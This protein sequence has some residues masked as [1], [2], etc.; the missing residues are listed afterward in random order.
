M[1]L[2]KKNKC[3]SSV[4]FAVLLL[5]HTLFISSI[6]AQG[7]GVR[8][9][10]YTSNKSGNFDIYLMNTISENHRLLTNHPAHDRDPTWSP[11]GRFLAYASNRDGISKIYVMDVRTGEH[12]RLTQR[13]AKEWAP[14]WSPDGK[15]IAFDSDAPEDILLMEWGKV[16]IASHIYKADINGENL[17]QLTD[18]GK[19]LKPSWSP[20]SQ[21][22]AFVSYHRGN[23]RKGIYVMDADGR[24]LRRL[25]DKAVQALNGILQSECTW[26][27]DGKQ[28]AFSM[29]V[30]RTEQVHLCAMD[31][32]GK[33]FRQLTQDG[34]IAGHKNVKESPFPQVRHPAW[35]PNGKWIVYVYSESFVIGNI[36]VI[37]ASGNGHGKPLVEGVARYQS[38][39][40]VPETYFSVS[41]STGKQTT[42]WGRLKKG[43]K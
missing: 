43:E 22:I 12:R 20:D 38:P 6:C 18:Q 33:N 41:P 28:I 39:A 3:M 35:S 15:W 25:D 11:D 4:F 7:Y 27:P 34:P 21:W 1:K 9:I 36:R 40:W 19:N 14:A 17:V 16:N 32:D 10:S 42:L 30:P 29:R 26:S 24:R 13:H 23:D 37:D 31:V 5:S 8:Y 2:T